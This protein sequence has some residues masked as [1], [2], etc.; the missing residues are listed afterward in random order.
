[1]K[2]LGA[3]AIDIVDARGGGGSG[4]SGGGGSDVLAAVA[5]AAA[6][7]VVVLDS[8]QAL[9]RGGG[10]CV[11]EV[12]RTALGKGMGAV[13]AIDFDEGDDFGELED[14]ATTVVDLVPLPKAKEFDGRVSVQKIEGKWLW[15]PVTA[16]EKRKEEERAAKKCGVVRTVGSP[17]SFLYSVH[18]S[19]AV[20]YYN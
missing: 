9:E 5:G 15:R 6:G 2:R 17:L 10:A 7:S 1:M 19:G 4:T 20:K 12:V 13:V 18:D 14:L 8:A 16:D 11:G 3:P